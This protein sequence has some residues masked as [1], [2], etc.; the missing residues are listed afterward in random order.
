VYDASETGPDEEN[1]MPATTAD[2]ALPGP[3][4]GSDGASASR[5]PRLLVVEPVAERAHE[6]ALRLAAHGID[7]VTT[8]SGAEAL[9]R[10]GLTRPDVLLVCASETDMAASVLISVVRA[11]MDL[12]V[13][14]GAG[15]DD[16][17][18]A[19]SGLGAGASALVAR[20]YRVDDVAR[21]VRS[22]HEPAEAEPPPA[23]ARLRRGVIELDPL[24]YTLRVEGRLVD[25]SPREFE[26]LR[27]LLEHAGRV[28]SR[29]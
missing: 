9:L 5:T 22:L 15:A 3:R 21:L 24:G 6:L 10:I 18:E 2:S 27:H 28:V 12:P 29:D 26:L 13:V 4:S 19:M 20:P 23:A 7:V 14:L 17:A 16:H 11:R 1:T 8:S 25:L